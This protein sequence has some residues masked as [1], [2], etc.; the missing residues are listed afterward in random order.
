MPHK[1][2]GY[3]YLK[4]GRNERALIELK[5]A[6]K[7]NPNDS[8][9]H[10]YLDEVYKQQHELKEAKKELEK[11]RDIAGRFKEKSKIPEIRWGILF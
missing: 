11:A 2:L 8:Y 9:A 1:N 10:W 7:I 3:I 4:T 5:K 6:I